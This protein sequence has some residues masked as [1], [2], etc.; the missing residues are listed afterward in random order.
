MLPQQSPPYQGLRRERNERSHERCGLD[1]PR[2]FG[3][4]AA[5]CRRAQ[6]RASGRTRGE[7]RGLS[8]ASRRNRRTARAGA[9]VRRAVAGRRI[10]SPGLFTRVVAAIVAVQFVLLRGR[11]RLRG[12]APH[13]G[14]LRMLWSGRHARCRLAARC[15]S[16]CC[17]PR[18][19]SSSRSA[20]RERWRS[21][22]GFAAREA[23]H[24][25]IATIVVVALIA[26]GGRALLLRRSRA[27]PR[28]DRIGV[29]DRRQSAGR[30]AGA[31]LRGRDDGRSLRA[32]KTR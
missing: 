32:G 6:G 19:A 28:S 30:S 23:P 25:V 31:E 20:R 24:V 29:A 5:G 12:A 1:R 3:R 11:D 15:A 10:S 18:P 2:S 14:Q 17:L 13:S 22:E 9:A 21:I 27:P 7:H 26:I 4:V 16:I 8:A